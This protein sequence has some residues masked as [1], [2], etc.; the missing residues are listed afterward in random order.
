MRI[1]AL[2]QGKAAGQL[3]HDLRRGRQPGYVDPER[4]ADNR[5]LIPPP[6]AAELRR[7][8]VE[9]RQR[10]GPSRALRSN[11]AIA[12]RGIITFGTSAQAL[13]A[14]QP[15]ETQDA[16]YRAVAGAIGRRYGVEVLGLVVH[17]D[18]AA[19]HAHVVWDCRTESGRPLSKEISG[20]EIQD[21]AA[22]A[23]A[24]LVPGIERGV[25]KLQRIEAG[26]PTANWVNRSVRELH[27]DLPAELEAIEA[28]IAAEREKE[29]TLQR[30]IGKLEAKAELT[31]KEAKRLQVYERRL[32]AAEARIGALR[33]E[34]AEIEARRMSPSS[35]LTGGLRRREAELL[36][37]EQGIRRAEQDLLKRRQEQEAELKASADRQRKELAR[38]EAES[39]AR[40]EVDDE[41]A[42][43][44][45]LAV[46]AI[47]EELV[48]PMREPG[49]W[50]QGRRFRLDR[51]E[52]VGPKLSGRSWTTAVWEDLRRFSA[53]CRLVLERLARQVA[54]LTAELDREKAARQR[55]EL[56]AADA[57]PAPAA[58]E[59]RQRAAHRLLV[60]A[61]MS[62]N[63]A[64]L[65]Q[66]LAEGAE[67][68]RPVERGRGQT[69][70]HLAARQGHA[71]AVGRLLR[72]GAD[73]ELR[74]DLGHTP[75]TAARSLASGRVSAD[76]RRRLRQAAERLEAAEQSPE[77][78]PSPDLSFSP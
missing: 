49:A 74:D 32:K 47:A 63:S 4:S 23:A 1:E 50:R 44:R 39:R 31:A 71:P 45:D 70:L 9:R 69:A 14:A 41:A 8:T 64:T 43:A 30:R 10:L 2:S 3:R 77:P 75:L 58:T 60:S 16:V 73:P 61:A 36:Q 26:E 12:A 67:P 53:R 33:Q 57:L 19:P 21:L 27:R 68:D 76:L 65:E 51:W 34:E 18:E 72:A 59:L 6:T 42:A 46:D 62:G 66:A 24:E 55:L 52:E 5:I 22:Q 13:L 54:K 38:L 17:A 29:A 35:L 37:R 56:E 28:S 11:A 25:P 78:F 40:I 7:R 15:S 48:E 20:S